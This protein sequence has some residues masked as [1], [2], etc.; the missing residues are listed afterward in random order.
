MLTTLIDLGTNTIFVV[1]WYDTLH[2]YHWVTNDKFLMV[3]FRK[4]TFLFSICDNFPILKF[5]YFLLYFLDEDNRG[6]NPSAEFCSAILWADE[7]KSYSA[8]ASNYV[9]FPAPLLEAKTVTEWLAHHHRL[10]EG[11]SPSLCCMA[12]NVSCCHTV[13]CLWSTLEQEHP[14]GEHSDVIIQPP[15]LDL[16][17]S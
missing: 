17:N 4:P 13:C 3:L 10:S 16:E 2:H 9:A 14:Y 8:C 6:W 15:D 12:R 5:N 7:L 1:L 11:Q